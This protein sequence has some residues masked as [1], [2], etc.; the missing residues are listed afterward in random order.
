MLKKRTVV[1]IDIA[2]DN[3]FLNSADI[4]PATS[5]GTF[6]SEKTGRG[7]LT[8][9]W[10]ETAEPVMCAYKL[11]TIHFKWFGLQNMVEGYAHTVRRNNISLHHA[12]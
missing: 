11:V 1:H 8:K 6:H 12:F 7:P 10:R 4:Q 5:P 9:N 3:E 2:N